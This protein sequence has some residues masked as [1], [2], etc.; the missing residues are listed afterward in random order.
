MNRNIAHKTGGCEV[1]K[2]YDK[3]C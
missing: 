1:T 2:I 3:V